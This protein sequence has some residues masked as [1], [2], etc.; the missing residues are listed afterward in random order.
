MLE[1]P[2]EPRLRWFS[3]FP[4]L[5]SGLTLKEASRDEEGFG[6]VALSLAGSLEAWEAL[7]GDATASENVDQE[8]EAVD[9]SQQ[10]TVN[11]RTVERKPRTGAQGTLTWITARGR[12]YV[13][14]RVFKWLALHQRPLSAKR[15]P[16]LERDDYRR[17][18]G[19]LLHTNDSTA[20]LPAQLFDF[21][22]C[23]GTMQC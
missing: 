10:G 15:Q 23:L 11:A 12:K 5:E 9:G 13:G 22:A 1:F 16:L 6:P 19:R 3:Q 2:G 17:R 18:L 4:S 7:R 14:G 21:F 20:D 8:L